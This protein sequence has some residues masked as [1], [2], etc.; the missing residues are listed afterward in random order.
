MVPSREENFHIAL[1]NRWVWHGRG[2]SDVPLF[3]LEMAAKLQMTKVSMAVLSFCF[4]KQT[5][6]VSCILRELQLNFYLF[7]K[8]VQ[9]FSFSLLQASSC[10]LSPVLP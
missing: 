2:T 5:L 8:Y 7:L 9:I 6:P 4:P 3:R 10:I 1:D